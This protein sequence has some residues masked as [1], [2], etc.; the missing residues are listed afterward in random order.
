METENSTEMMVEGESATG[1][2][3][4]ALDTAEGNKKNFHV[5]QALQL[6]IAEEE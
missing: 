4:R 1:H 2:L 3:Q 6:L 5:R